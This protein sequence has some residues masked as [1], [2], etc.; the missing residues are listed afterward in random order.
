VLFFER[1]FKS[2]YLLFLVGLLVLPV[3][4]GSYYLAHGLNPLHNIL[5]NKNAALQ[6]NSTNE[7][8]TSQLYYLRVIT[9]NFK[10]FGLYFFLFLPAL[11]LA[12]MRR[13]RGALILALWAGLLLIILEFGVVNISPLIEIVKVRK[14]LNYVTVPL[15]LLAAWAL[16][17]LRPWLRAT[18]LV[19]LI[20]TSLYFLKP[21]QYRANMTPEASGAYVRQIAR[22]LENAPSKPIYADRRTQAMLTIFSDFEFRPDRFRNL[23]D[24]ESPLDLKDCYVVIN[25]FYVRFDSAAPWA[26]VPQFVA[27]YPE[28][29]PP[30]WKVKSFLFSAVYTVP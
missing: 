19:F 30:N 20:G 5:L 13:E 12:V 14:F 6:V 27:H 15:V 22:F 17:H 18:I 1:T 10:V 2:A 25:G 26:K 4:E 29:I 23:Y 16:L 21:Y 28:G 7:C 3:S 24:V 11:S 8:S 9:G